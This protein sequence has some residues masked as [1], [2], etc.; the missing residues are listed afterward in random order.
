VGSGVDEASLENW[1]YIDLGRRS[2]TSMDVFTPALLGEAESP[3]VSAERE[4][5]YPGRFCKVFSIVRGGSRLRRLPAAL[6]SSSSCFASMRLCAAKASRGDN[7]GGT[8]PARCNRGD[9]KPPR[10]D[11]MPLPSRTP[12][13]D[14]ERTSMKVGLLAIFSSGNSPST[15]GICA[16]SS[17]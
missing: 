7:W 6:L 2:G 5:K 8:A 9:G 16:L 11:A 4:R 14:C 10:G 12:L 3:A 15:L 1:G 17:V 13:C